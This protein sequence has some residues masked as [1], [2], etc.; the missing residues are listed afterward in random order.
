MLVGSVI[1]M[2]GHV[3]VEGVLASNGRRVVFYD[4]HNLIVNNG[5]TVVSELLGQALATT[6]AP[7]ASYN[8][9]GSIWV[10][11]RTTGLLSTAG[12]TT[13]AA[14][15]T[16]L[17]GTLVQRLPVLSSGVT[18]NTTPI[19]VDFRASLGTTQG[20]GYDIEEV[21]LFTAGSNP[22]NPDLAAAGSP[23][24]RMFARQV[25]PTIT[26]TSALA[27]DFTWRIGFVAS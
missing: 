26:K 6:N 11:G 24:P 22:A 17:Q 8:G 25:V 15:Q 20:N 23:A 4:S 18:F 10:G 13:P 21:G 1:R 19:S 7:A 3:K 27:L 5:L 14:S 2:W 16:G 9:I 12:T